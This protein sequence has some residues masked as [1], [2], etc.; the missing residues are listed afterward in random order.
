VISHGAPEMTAVCS[1]TLLCWLIM[2]W[3]ELH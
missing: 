1:L 3:S 2:T